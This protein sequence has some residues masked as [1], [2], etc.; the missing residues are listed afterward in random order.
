MGHLAPGRRDLAR[1]ALDRGLNLAEPEQLRRPVLEAPARLRRLI[2]QDPRL[3]ERH[4]WLT[5]SPI[6]YSRATAAVAASPPQP[7]VE[8]LTDKEREVLRHLSSL[9]STDEIARAMLVSV[10]TVKTHVRGVLRKLAVSHRNEAVRRGREL[11]LI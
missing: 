7:V 9:L 10:N 6:R 11:G 5:R 2:S 4:P 8:R 3:A 1:D